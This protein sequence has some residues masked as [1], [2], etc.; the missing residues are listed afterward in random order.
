[1]K[2]KRGSIGR[3]AIF[4]FT[5]FCGVFFMLKSENHLL[6]K[7]NNDKYSQKTDNQISTNV[8]NLFDIQEG[9]AIDDDLN[10]VLFDANILFEKWSPYTLNLH[11]Y[12]S[13]PVIIT[14]DNYSYI[15]LPRYILFHS[16]RIP[17]C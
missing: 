1:M 10:Q 12:S 16:L 4:F 11:F 17:S 7:T 2:T 14:T 9:L 15:T 8:F 3:Y 13:Q 5:I 6:L